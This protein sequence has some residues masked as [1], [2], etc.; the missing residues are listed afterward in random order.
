MYTS[1]T[2]TTPNGITRIEIY[3]DGISVKIIRDRVY[4]K[5]IQ[6]KDYYINMMRSVKG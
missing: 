3:L 2:T 6:Q 4:E 1:Q 5:A